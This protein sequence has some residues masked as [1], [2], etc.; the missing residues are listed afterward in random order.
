MPICTVCKEDKPVEGFAKDKARK[1][2]HSHRCKECQK[3]LS[4]KH[5]KANKKTYMTRQETRRQKHITRV[6]EYKSITGCIECGDTRFYVLDLHHRNSDEKEFS[7]GELT[8]GNWEKIQRE[9][10]KCD[11]LC[12][13]CHREL[14]HIES[15][16]G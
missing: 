15:M 4:G 5:Y 16:E 13:N 7:V 8:H 10:D 11:V 3:T 14:H 6:N 1:S 12:S 9:I 2:G